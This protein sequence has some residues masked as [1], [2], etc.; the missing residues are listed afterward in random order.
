MLKSIIYHAATDA[1]LL[2]RQNTHN[3]AFLCVSTNHVKK[4]FFFFCINYYTENIIK[5]SVSLKMKFFFC[6]FI[7]LNSLIHNRLIQR[8]HAALKAGAYSA[9]FMVISFL[10]RRC[11]P[12]TRCIK[13][14]SD[15]PCYNVIFY[16]RRTE[17]KY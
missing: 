6:Y 13:K 12:V 2:L 15:Q 9:I 1:D 5:K 16:L 7:S 14:I 8:A 17:H 10:Q 11:H 4:I 3:T